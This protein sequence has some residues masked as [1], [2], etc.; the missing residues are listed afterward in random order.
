MNKETT[1][2]SFETFNPNFTTQSKPNS[3]FVYVSTSTPSA[4][5]MI[6]TQYQTLSDK[7][8]LEMLTKLNEWIDDK[9][10]EIR[11]SLFP[12]K[13]YTEKQV[14]MAMH[15]NTLTKETYNQILEQLIPIELPSDEEVKVKSKKL[16]F[17]VRVN[18]DLYNEALNEGFFLG[19]E[20]IKEQILNQNK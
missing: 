3:E 10:A 19:V 20:W 6:S 16:P 8:K 7:E 17:E 14:I 5:V 2:H 1:N 18:N 4:I 12:V 11:E 13:L 15:L 9:Q